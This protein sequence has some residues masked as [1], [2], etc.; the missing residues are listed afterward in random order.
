[1]LM[2]FKQFLMHGLSFLKLI[3]CVRAHICVKIMVIFWLKS[4]R[5]GLFY[6]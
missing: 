3:V 2:K 5:E 4:G 1:M 6:I